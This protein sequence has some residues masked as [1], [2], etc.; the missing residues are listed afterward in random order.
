MAVDTVQNSTIN[1]CLSDQWRTPIPINTHPYYTIDST[2]SVSFGVISSSYEL[3]ETEKQRKQ[4]S[5]A[6]P[7]AL[8][9]VQCDV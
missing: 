5:S 6:W 9:V 1:V 8:G 3:V 7:W 2:N 4:H